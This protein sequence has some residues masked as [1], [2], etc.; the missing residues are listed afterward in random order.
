M[1]RFIYYLDKVFIV[2]LYFSSFK[3]LTRAYLVKTSM[4]NNK[5]LIFL[6]F[7]DNDSMSAKSAT[8]ILSLNPVYNYL[9]LNF[10]ITIYI[11]LQLVVHLHTLLIL[12][13]Y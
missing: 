11:I 4:A 1:I 2:A 12:F 3:S 6:L 5:Y 9:L 7:E 8:Q 13:S 10:L